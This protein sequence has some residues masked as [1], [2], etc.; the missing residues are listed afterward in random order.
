MSGICFVSQSTL[1]APIARVNGAIISDDDLKASLAALSEGQ[2]ANVLKD[3][4]SKEQILENLIERELLVQSGRGQKLDQTK[5]YTESVENFKK[6]LLAEMV[7]QKNID[8]QL[9]STTLRKYYD[10]NQHRF[11]TGRV[12]VQHIVLKTEK[13]GLE[14]LKLAKDPSQD[15][16]V[17]AEKYSI[18]PGAKN[19]RGELGYITRDRM[20]P[21]FTEAAFVAKNGSIVGPVRTNY[22]YHVIKV[23]DREIGRTLGYDEAELRVK[24]EFKQELLTLYLSRLKTKAKIERLSAA[25]KEIK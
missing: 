24:A 6:Q 13:Q 25:L 14:V 21:E 12:R 19:N 15:F 9:T 17:L 4:P 16:Q 7:I 23:I 18:D 2:R 8:S 10:S 20:V 11:S 1:A 3:D 22:G 5:I